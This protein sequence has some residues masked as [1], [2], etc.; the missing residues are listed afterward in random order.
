MVDNK[1]DGV[2]GYSDVDGETNVASP[3]PGSEPK[4]KPLNPEEYAE[5]QKEARKEDEK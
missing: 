2:D 4:L 1:I 3:D 5:A